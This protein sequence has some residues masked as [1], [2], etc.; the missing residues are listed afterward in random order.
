MT[1]KEL[2]ELLA[3]YREEMTVIVDLHSDYVEAGAPKVIIGVPTND[4]IMRAHPTMSDAN[5][6]KQQDYLLIGCG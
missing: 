6:S 2:M 5:K 1:V 4:W 3:N